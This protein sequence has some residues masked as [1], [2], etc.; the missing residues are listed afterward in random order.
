[1]ST[2]SFNEFSCLVHIRR[3]DVEV[4]LSGFLD[5]LHALERVFEVV[6]CDHQLYLFNNHPFSLIPRLASCLSRVLLIDG[7][8]SGPCSFDYLAPLPPF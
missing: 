6:L 3:I 1:V 5:L 8:W 4:A 2:F 7:N